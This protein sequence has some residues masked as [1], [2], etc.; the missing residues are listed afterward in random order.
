[1]WK[2]AA[3]LGFAAIAVLPHRKVLHQR[4]FMRHGTCPVPFFSAMFLETLLLFPPGCYSTTTSRQEYES[5]FQGSFSLLRPKI[6]KG[7]VTGRSCGGKLKRLV[8]A[9]EHG[10]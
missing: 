8:R 6:S 2:V 10:G 7:E 1:F 4:W 9:G 3:F 5:S